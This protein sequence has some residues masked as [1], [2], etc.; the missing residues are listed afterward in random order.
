MAYTAGQLHLVAGAAPGTC[1]Y[2]YNST[3]PVDEV[4]D[5]GYFNNV[6]DNLNLAVGDIIECVQASSVDGGFIDGTVDEF[7]RFIVTNVIANDAAASAGAVN[8]AEIAGT[9]GVSSGA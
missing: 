8:I 5:A 1:I 2:R 9:G 7:K 6:D 4:E 3:D